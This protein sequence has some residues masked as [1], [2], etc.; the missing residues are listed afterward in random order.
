MRDKRFIRVSARDSRYLEYDDGSTYIPMG[1]NLCFPRFARGEDEVMA[2]FRRNLT[3]LAE[4][5]GNFVRIWLGSP[6][7]ELETRREGVYETEQLEHMAAVTELA[8][9]LGLRIKFTLEHFRR[10]EPGR[11]AEIFPGAASFVKEVYHRNRGGS[12]ENTAEF[13]STDAGHRLF[14]AKLDVLAKRFAQSPAVMGWELWNE[15]NCCGEPELW[16]KWT[17]AMLPELKRR[18][19]RHLTMQSLGS[20][21]SPRSEPGY[22]CLGA[23]HHNDSDQEHRNLYTGAEF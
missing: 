7:F 3:L 9:E 16:M 12:F 2:Y 13:M 14:L 1:I 10:L 11:Q 17:E 6:F 5:G 23:L 19:P 18:F 8:G 22:R 21:D 15:V 4:H 20:F